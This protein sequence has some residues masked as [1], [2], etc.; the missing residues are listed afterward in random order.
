LFGTIAQSNGPRLVMLCIGCGLA[1]VLPLHV[2]VISTLINLLADPAFEQ[3]ASAEAARKLFLTQALVSA[4]LMT[5]SAALLTGIYLF[6]LNLGRWFNRR[7]ARHPL[8]Q[9]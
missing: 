7:N 6:Y 3:V 1:M 4:G 8:K 9:R 5:A 2:T